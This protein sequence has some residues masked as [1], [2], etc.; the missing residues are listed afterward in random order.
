MMTSVLLGFLRGYRWMRPALGPPRCRFFPT[1]SHYALEAVELHGAMK[2]SW[3]A[4]VRISKCHPLN[5]GGFDPVP[6]RHVGS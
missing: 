3:L 4:L 5:R 1:C 2:G 6:E